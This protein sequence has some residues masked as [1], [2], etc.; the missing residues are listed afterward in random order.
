M[1]ATAKVPAWRRY[2]RLLRPDVEA[3]IDEELRFHFDERID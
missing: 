3:D 1:H 2:L